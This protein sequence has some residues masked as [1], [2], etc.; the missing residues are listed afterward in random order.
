MDDPFEEAAPEAAPP[1]PKKRSLFSSAAIAKS[2]A[3]EEAVEFFSRAKELY[4]QQL[5]QEERKRQKRLLKLERK[6][7]STSADTKEITPP[8]EKRRRVSAQSKT[9]DEYSSDESRNHNDDSISRARRQSSHSSPGSRRSRQGSDSHNGQASPTSLSARYNRDTSTPKPQSPKP[10]ASTGCI[11]LSDSEDDKPTM[12][13][14]VRRSPKKQLVT[15]IDSDDDFPSPKKP[16]VEPA[17]VEEDLFSD[18]EFPELV[19]AAKERAMKKAEEAARSAKAFGEQN[20][21]SNDAEDDIFETGSANSDP[22]VEILISSQMAD[23]IPIRV[24]RKISQKLAEVRFAWCD[25]QV[26]N[27]EPMSSD[28]KKEV[29]LT[30]KHHTLY[31]FSTLQGLGLKV[32]EHGNLVSSTDSISSDGRV[33]LEA[34]TK[35]AYETYQKREA[36]RKQ[37]EE[38]HSDE[39]AEQKEPPIKK[40]KLVLRSKNLPDFKLVVKPSTT[41]ER[42]ADAFRNANDIPDENSVTLHLD[43]DELDPS[44]TAEDLDLE[45]MDALE[46]HIK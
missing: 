12:K 46:V 36:A 1:P 37:K 16:I 24:R 34:W 43:G 40:T 23:T 6:R 29:F 35:Q 19:K 18:E 15:L 3:A 21:A 26:F 44:D 45:D 33:H 30:Y 9:H 31:D 22:P 41:V 8:E 11:T 13:L 4:P 32:D 42:I 25:R 20:H 2:T 7:S 28:M 17:V 38:G 27:G 39:P 5:A 14:P 10:P